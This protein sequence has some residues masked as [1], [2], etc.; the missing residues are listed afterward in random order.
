MGCC[1]SPWPNGEASS[2]NSSCMLSLQEAQ[3]LRRWV[4]AHQSRS[5]NTVSKHRLECCVRGCRR[6]AARGIVGSINKGTVFFKTHIS[7][8]QH[9]AYIMWHP[10]FVH[11]LRDGKRWPPPLECGFKE[12]LATG[13][14]VRV[15]EK[16]FLHP[17]VPCRVKR[18]HGAEQQAWRAVIPVW[19]PLC[20]NLLLRDRETALDWARW[21][22]L[23]FH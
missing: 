10:M 11:A 9:Q 15:E 19:L 17:R 18:E 13:M 22:P 7:A 12:G 8:H 23:H 1:I 21:I 5:A 6:W 4:S 20:Q 3:W 2:L 14:S 16:G